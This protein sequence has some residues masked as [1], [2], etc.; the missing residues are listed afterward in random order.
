MSQM[1]DPT[2]GLVGFESAL[3]AGQIYPHN[4]SLY[5]D[6]LVFLDEAEGI[7]RRTYALM[8]GKS[9]K[10]VAVYFLE[11]NIGNIPC[12]DLGYAVAE[13]YRGQRNAQ[14]IIEK[15]LAQLKHEVR[16]QIHNFCVEVIVPADNL[17]S[18][19]VASRAFAVAPNKILDSASGKP[20]V[21]YLEFIEL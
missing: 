6:L 3:S 13:P 14:A 17:A 20:S 2:L 15:S 1:Q 10:A 18:L 11:K 12:F 7:P 8:D 19:K 21:Q 5:P 16:G 9:V 4:S